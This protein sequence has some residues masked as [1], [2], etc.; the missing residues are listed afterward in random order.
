[1]KKALSPGRDTFKHLNSFFLAFDHIPFVHELHR[2]FLAG[3]PRFGA[4]DGNF[5]DAV[6]IYEDAVRIVEKKASDL[7]YVSKLLTL[8]RNLYS[9]LEDILS[10]SGDDLRHDFLVVIPV[11]E[12][13]MMLKKCVDSLIDQ[14]RLFRYGGMREE[15]DGKSFFKKISLHI[16][17]D[18]ADISNRTATRKIAGEALEAGLRTRYFGLSEQSD[19]VK[20]IPTDLRGKLSGVIGEFAGS[21]P[22]HKGASVTRNIAMLYLRSMLNEV[23]RMEVDQPQNRVRRNRKTLVFFLDSDEEFCV[24]VDRS[25][26]VADIPFINYFYW[27][28]KI[29]T[30]TGAKVLTG[31]VVGDP[32]VSPSVMV[33]T[34]LDDILAFFDNLSPDEIQSPCKYHERERAG[35]FSA[36][37]H[38]MAELFGYKGLTSPKQYHCALKGNH[39][40]KDC[41][42]DFSLR[43]GGFFSGFHPTRVQ[44]Y[45]HRDFLETEAAR[46]VYTG[47]YVFA[48]DGLDY[49][50]PFANLQLRMAGPVLGRILRKR[51][52]ETF[53]SANLPLL[54]KRTVPG[55]HVDEFRSGISR[56]GEIPDLSGEYYRQFWGD[57]MLFSIEKMTEAGYPEKKFKKAEITGI[58]SAV[59]DDLWRLYSEKRAEIALK[60][61]KIREYLAIGSGWW[62]GDEELMRAVGNFNSFCSI[63]EANFIPGSEIV[64]NLAGQVVNGLYGDRITEAIFA[65]YEDSSAWED[66]MDIG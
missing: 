57:V 21:V 60:I 35:K 58:V 40:L 5:H 10:K 3:P 43:T 12:R 37:Y 7:E 45:H 13:P 24:R 47:N 38:D 30:K 29:F 25:G 61:I 15:A 59:R 55:N 16:I 9:E 6:S 42:V 64:K 32:P 51:L 63:V 22:P 26:E 39:T 53:V 62:A 50:I 34:F 41:A 20:K 56:S 1:M 23:S 33:N 65:Y 49:F 66:L 28:D 11:A 17:D 52:G 36:E 27:M 48:E 4:D 14:C 46:T 44:M 2:R 19:A 54:H 18:S 8:Q 31:K